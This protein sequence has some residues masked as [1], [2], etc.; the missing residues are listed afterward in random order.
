MFSLKNNYMEVKMTEG[1][2]FDTLNGTLKDTDRTL[3]KW[4]NGMCSFYKEYGTI[5]KF[6]EE[7]FKSLCEPLT[8][9]NKGSEEMIDVRI[10]V[11][12]YLIKCAIPDKKIM[13]FYNTIYQQAIG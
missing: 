7:E 4:I 12:T 3:E 11:I 1:K 10:N 5:G 2:L 9:A 6:N 13:N 8:E